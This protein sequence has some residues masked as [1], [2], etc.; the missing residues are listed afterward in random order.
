[1]SK[2]E[3]IASYAA[4]VSRVIDHIWRN[5]DRAP[6]LDELAGVACLSPYHFHR[7][8]HAVCDETVVET[9]RRLRLHRS[10]VDLVATNGVAARMPLARIARRAGYGSLSAFS[11]AFAAAHG[12]PPA[13]FRARRLAPFPHPGLKENPTMTDLDVTIS[14]APA[15][16]LAAFPHRGDYQ[17]I[18]HSFERLFAWAVGKGLPLSEA[19]MIGIYYD[20]PEATPLKDLRAHAC[21]EVGPG[22]KADGEVEIVEMKETRIASLIHKGPYAE[23]PRAYAKLYKSWLPGSGEQPGAEPCFEE[24]LNNPRALPPSEWLTRVCM[25][26]A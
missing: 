9:Q 19:R 16:R 3:T 8:Y 10:A 2:P 7:V 1:M 25:P 24:Y 18:G 21:I 26:L 23:L 20:D 22:V 13:A 12:V 4:R 14:R 6:S 11:R 5:L 15:A 17:T